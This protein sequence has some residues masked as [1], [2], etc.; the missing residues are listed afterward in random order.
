M[1]C[2]DIGKLFLRVFLEQFTLLFFLYLFIINIINQFYFSKKDIPVAN[3]RTHTVHCAKNA[4]KVSKDNTTKAS[5]NSDEPMLP[6]EFC[7]DL[8][9]MRK[10]LEHQV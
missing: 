10:L 1:K 7:D 9:P 4:T 8:I 3:Y 6:C 5:S 2:A